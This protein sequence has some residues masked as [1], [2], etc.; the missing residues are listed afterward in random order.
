MMTYLREHELEIDPTALATGGTADILR[1]TSH[2]VAVLYKR[3]KPEYR[4]KVD[5]AALMRLVEWRANLPTDLCRQLD[6]RC[7]W[8]TAVVFHN[9]GEAAGVLMPRTPAILGS[10][11]AYR[12]SVQVRTLSKLR[13]LAMDLPD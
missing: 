11:S 7:A 10:I 6:E 1:C 8:P 2:G 4:S 9:R 3:Y 5:T 13:R 12:P